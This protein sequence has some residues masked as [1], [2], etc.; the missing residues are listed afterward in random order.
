MKNFIK[1]LGLLVSSYIIVIAISTVGIVECAYVLLRTH[2]ES[3]YWV[4]YIPFFLSV[5]VATF[6]VTYVNDGKD[7]HFRNKVVGNMVF[8]TAAVG[9]SGYCYLT[10]GEINDLSTVWTVAK[11]LGYQFIVGS[12]VVKVIE[13]AFK[14][15]FVK[16]IWK[17]IVH[18]YALCQRDLKLGEMTEVIDTDGKLY[19]GI[20][21]QGNGTKEEHF[22][23]ILASGTKYFKEE[24]LINT[25]QF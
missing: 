23:L 21:V 16:N 9:F 1:C 18:N 17:E 12:G 10:Y 11:D 2:N 7:L 13:R 8:M 4:C 3:Y 5:Y 19:I 15:N 20:L 22:G 14:T 6:L 24:C 25:H